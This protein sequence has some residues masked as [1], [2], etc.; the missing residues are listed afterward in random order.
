MMKSKNMLIL[1]VTS[2]L[3]YGCLGPQTY[4]SNVFNTVYDLYFPVQ[5]TEGKPVMNYKVVADITDNQQTFNYTLYFF[6][7]G[8]S[9]TSVT[10][11]T[12]EEVLTTETITAIY[13]YQEEGI[14]ASRYFG[15]NT[16]ET[17]KVFS[18]FEDGGFD[19]VTEAIETVETNLTEEIRS[20]INNQATN[21]IIGGQPE[22]QDE[23][24]YTLPVA[25]FVD[26]DSFEDITSFVPTDLT[27]VV[28]F[29]TST[30]ET[31][32]EVEASSAT[33]NYEITL[34]LSSYDAVLASTHLLSSSAK[35]TYEGYTA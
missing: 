15:N 17:E 26:L 10:P 11:A 31:T 35:L 19:V 4:F 6:E 33:E 1:G 7:T 14:F 22:T 24:V 29:V 27:V 8:M 9:L 21:L 5:D 30:N 16:V 18:P 13:D 25:Q 28:T 3:M 20:I 12:V 23:K 32:I 34:N 2:V